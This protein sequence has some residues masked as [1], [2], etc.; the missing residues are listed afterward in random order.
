MASKNKYWTGLEELHNTESFQKAQQNEFPEDMSVDEFLGKSSLN[1]MTSGRRDFLKFLGFSVAAATVTA[2]ETPVIKSIPYVNKPEDV[3][4]GVANFY[5]STYYDGIDYA[6]ILVKTRE[7]RPIYIKGNKHFGVTKGVLNSRVNSSVLSLYDGARLKNPVLKGEETSWT[8]LDNAV[9]KALNDTKAKQGNIRVLS[10]SVISPSTKQVVGK[11][12][13]NFKS[14]EE[15]VKHVTFDEVSYSAIRKANQESFG[16]AI[17]PSYDFS[18]AKTI[19]SVGA[20]FLG[21]WLFANEFQGQ[22]TVNRKPENGKM[23]RHFQFESLMSL[24]GSN[25]DVRIP[26]R[27]SE[28]GLVLLS[29]YNQL[30]KK[31]G[32]APAGNVADSVAAKTAKA[33]EELWATKGQGLVVSGSNVTANQ[34]LVNAINNLLGNYGTTINLN[35]PLNLYQGNDQKVEELIAEMANGKVDVLLIHGV[36]PA[37]S[38]FNSDKFKAA[39]AKVKFKVSFSGY[40]DETAS[41]CD[42]IAVDNHYLESWNDAEVKKG[43]FSLSQ[44]AISNLFNTRQAQQSLMVWSGDNREY[45]D[46]IKSVWTTSVMT[47][48]GATDLAA[49]FWNKAVHNGSV[50]TK[51]VAEG[52]FLFDADIRRHSAALARASKVD[53]DK[54]E[55]VFY[56]KVTMG[57]GN[58]AGN[59]WLQE[60]PDPITKVTWDNYITMAPADV[61]DGSY[62]DDLGQES[63]AS[64][65]KVTVNGKTVE[66]PVYPCP[67]QKPGTIGIALGYGRG[68]NG[69]NIGKAAFQTGEYGGHLTDENGNLIPIGKNAFGLLNLVDGDVQYSAANV[70]VER[71]EKEYPLACTQTHHTVMGRDSIVRET[72]LSVYNKG[73]KDD[74]NP[75]HMLAYHTAESDKAPVS[76]ID[77]WQAHPVENVGHR[78]GMSIDLNTC[79][80]CGTCITACHSENNVPVVGKDEVRRSRDMHWLRIDRYFSSSVEEGKK[81]RGEDFSYTE[82]ENPDENPQ[83]VHMP[84][85]CQH[86]NHAPCETVCPV[87]ATTHSNEGLNQMT[88]NRCIGTRYCANNCPYKV[89][90]FNWFNYQEYKKFTEVNPAQDDLGRLVLNPDVTVRARGVMEKCSLCVQRIQAGKLEAKKAGEPVADGAIETACSD[91]CPTGAI[92]FGDLNDKKSAA[93]VKAN[94]DRGYNAIEEV[95][96]RPN[97]YYMVKVRN[98]EA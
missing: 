5:A 86:C 63:P 94:S 96:T 42:A 21:T 19:V 23:S 55:V 75:A 24:T 37:Y 36:N 91:S 95:G 44:P 3:N 67:G 1:E 39:L 81:H 97:I 65:A 58:Q 18:K 16:S 11:F 71:L 93:A 9:R 77:L 31:A 28:E 30:A 49:N 66:L 41:L 72:S 61:A 85:M 98:V 10:S 4:P 47:A 29:I 46:V 70:S 74:F 56:Q 25:A 73:N 35:Q 48:A 87:A 92:T 68:A 53:S 26:V 34:V 69:E 7:G 45:L 80:G 84:M 59:P 32:V 15:S 88:Y 79:Y 51:V 12:F 50:S 13:E 76:E 27:P 52:E 17:I 2:C 6:N 82:M 14:T 64:M 89:R 62:N 38:Y 90:R 60:T 57:V 83:V 33:S 54:V 8:K 43:E 40:A 78:W 20:D 22:Y